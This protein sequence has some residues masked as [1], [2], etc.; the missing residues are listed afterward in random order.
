M[1]SLRRQ[2]L[3]SGELEHSLKH[4]FGDDSGRLRALIHFGGSCGE[5]RT[6]FAA[7]ELPRAGT[8]DDEE[9]PWPQDVV[10]RTLLRWRS[11]HDETKAGSQPAAP[12]G[13]KPIHDAWLRRS[14]REPSAFCRL[15]LEEARLM[16]LTGH[17]TGLP[18]LE[19]TLTLVSDAQ[20]RCF[21]ETRRCT[22]RAIAHIYLAAAV[23]RCGARQDAI[24]HFRSARDCLQ[25][26][27]ADPEVYLLYHLHRYWCRIDVSLGSGHF[28]DGAERHLK[29]CCQAWRS[30]GHIAE[31]GLALGKK[32]RDTSRDRE[33]FRRFSEALDCIPERCAWD[34]I[35]CLYQ[36]ADLGERLNDPEGLRRA[37]P[38]AETIMERYDFPV[39]RPE[40][41]HLRGI[42][43]RWN[44][45]YDAADEALQKAIAAHLKSRQYLAA[46]SSLRDR[47]VLSRERENTHA[48]PMLRD[49]FLHIATAPAARPWNSWD[50]S[51][52]LDLAR[53]VEVVDIERLEVTLASKPEPG[54]TTT[55]AKTDHSAPADGEETP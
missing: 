9:S 14:V 27:C 13:I 18:A 35:W 55:P 52:I 30:P 46:L 12:L 49:E 33:A 11:E 25:H 51:T 44:H 48:L 7:V 50:I 6:S 17:E 16:E 45:N 47:Y 41:M 34:R 37:L 26:G 29:Q 20:L 21:G 31:V 53:N 22:L 42:L 43:E 28:V 1:P 3:S 23:A 15:V 54:P 19:Q 36:V 4:G 2:H 39:L 32:L 8:H 10:A 24:E 40:L 38:E 5:C